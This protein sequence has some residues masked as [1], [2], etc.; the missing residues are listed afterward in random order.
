MLYRIYWVHLA[1]VMNDLGFGL[2][3]NLTVNNEQ[4][5]FNRQ[6][7]PSPSC[8]F[9]A[10]ARCGHGNGHPPLMGEGRSDNGF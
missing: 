9:C 8:V 5:Q 4:F 1:Q 7:P 2:L 10:C 6:E 3:L